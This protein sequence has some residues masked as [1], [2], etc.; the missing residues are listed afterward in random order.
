MHLFKSEIYKDLAINFPLYFTTQNVTYFNITDQLNIVIDRDQQ[1]F[2]DYQYDDVI[3]FCN[4]NNV[5]L[6]VSNPTFEFWLMLHFPEVDTEDKVKMF[7]N[8]YI[9]KSKRYLEKKLYE[10]CKYRKSNLNFKDFEPYIYD[11]IKR[12]K[13]Y[14]EDLKNL[15]NNLGSNIGILINNMLKNNKKNCLE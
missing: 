10:I 4:D 13:E 8:R 3:K 7:E 1:N 9:N 14:P 12:E 15:K 11:A 2:K 6:Y 5:N